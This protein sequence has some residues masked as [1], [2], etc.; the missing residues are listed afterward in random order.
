MHASV[1]AR[2]SGAAKSWNLA[3]IAAHIDCA[4]AS[5]PSG[6]LARVGHLGRRGDHRD[7]LVGAEEV[8]DVDPVLLRTQAKG[9]KLR[10]PETRLL[11][12][13]HWLVHTLQD[14]FDNA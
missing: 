5:C 3:G 1:R 8:E 7:P 4:H 9:Q 14:Y 2:H 12:S 10:P 13:E 11:H 6:T